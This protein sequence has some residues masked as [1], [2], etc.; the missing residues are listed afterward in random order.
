MLDGT[1]DVLLDVFS[2]VLR[3]GIILG[4]GEERRIAKIRKHF[5]LVRAPP[6]DLVGRNV[7]RF[8]GHQNKPILPLPAAKNVGGRTGPKRC[9]KTQ[10]VLGTAGMRKVDG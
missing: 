9:I 4:A 7:G 2:A 8:V 3:E 10:T 5:K 1:L 6:I